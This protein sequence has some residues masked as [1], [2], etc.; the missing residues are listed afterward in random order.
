MSKHASD[1]TD[2]PASA[3]KVGWRRALA[4]IIVVPGVL[5]TTRRHCAAAAASRSRSTTAS[6][7]STPHATCRSWAAHS[8]R[9]GGQISPRWLMNPSRPS[10]SASA[11]SPAMSA[12][13]SAAARSAL[14]G[15]T[16]TM[17]RMGEK[18]APIHLDH[19]LA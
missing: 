17:P 7:V 2:Q 3:P 11:N 5:T 13:S 8:A 6:T 10:R 4:R 18:L 1:R 19:T 16:H 15:E 9:V 12:D 14:S